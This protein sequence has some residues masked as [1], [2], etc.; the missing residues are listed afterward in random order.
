MLELKLIVCPVDFSEF[1][2][3]AYRHALSL[4]EHYRAKLV[5]QHV[6]ELWRHPSLSFAPSGHLYTEFCQLLSENSKDQLQKFVKSHTHDEIQPELVVQMG[7][8]SDF[9]LWLAQSQKA[10][11]IVMGTHGLEGMTI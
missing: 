11:L 8:A 2:I 3:T 4:A 5:V 10:D 7:I 9:I 1:S 6:V